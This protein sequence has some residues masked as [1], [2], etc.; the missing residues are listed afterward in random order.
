M[1]ENT[2]NHNSCEILSSLI[3]SRLS[4]AQMDWMN[5]SMLFDN[6]TLFFQNF[7]LISRMIPSLSPDW[8]PSEKIILEQLYPG[9]ISGQWNLQQLCRCLLMLHIPEDQNT[10]IVKK[11]TQSADINELVC[12]YKG[13]F[14][15]ENAHEFISLVEEGIRTN[16]TS[17]FD[18]IALLNPFAAKYLPLDSWNQ[19]ILKA[20][21]MGRP[22]YQ[23]INLD[24]RK[25]EKLAFI[26]TD[27][28]HERWSAGRTVSPEIWRLMD[29]FVNK[30]V[31]SDLLKVIESG[32]QLSK[33]AAI[34]VLREN[35]S[36][37]CNNILRPINTTLWNYIGEQYYIQINK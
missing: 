8:N 17:I 7:G 33:Q 30:E 16:I 2:L 14:F 1:T 25:N 28:I 34:I 22:L 3:Q 35:A 5:V 31:T 19:L 32:D 18:S 24:L 29:G 20:L 11:L 36:N 27:Y 21:F 15:L 10:T 9:F 23:I 37:T 26:A 12:I 13:I 6:E 4:E